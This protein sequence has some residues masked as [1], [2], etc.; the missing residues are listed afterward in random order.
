[1][2]RVMAVSCSAIS[3]KGFNKPDARNK[4]NDIYRYGHGGTVWQSHAGQ[5]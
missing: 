4:D 2:F 5:L 1:M 3:I